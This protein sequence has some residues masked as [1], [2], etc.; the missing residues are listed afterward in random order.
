MP[1]QLPIYTGIQLI[2]MLPGQ[3]LLRPESLLFLQFSRRGKAVRTP[4]GLLHLG[5]GLGRYGF[6]LSAAGQCGQR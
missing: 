5:L 4:P 6:R 3:I 2:S 1:E